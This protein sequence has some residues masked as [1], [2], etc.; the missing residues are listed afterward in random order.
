MTVREPED[1]VVQTELFGIQVEVVLGD[2]PGSNFVGY[3][4]LAPVLVLDV[5]MALDTLLWPADVAFSR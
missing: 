5:R 3:Y 4:W 2:I 1:G